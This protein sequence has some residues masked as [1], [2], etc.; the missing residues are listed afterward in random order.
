M[1]IHSFWESFNFAL[2][3]ISHTLKTQRNMRIH[4]I[5]AFLVLILSLLLDITK[6]ELII[7]FFSISFVIAAELINTSIE[8][9][10]NMLSQQYSFQARIAKNIAAGAVFM[11]AV[12]F[13]VIGYL[14]F[15][16]KLRRLTLDLILEI[17]Q[18]PFHL[19]F[20]NLSLLFIIV[21]YLKALNERGTPLKGGMPS[22]HSAIAF[23]I[24]TIITYLSGDILIASLAI[25]LALSVIQSRLESG[26]HDLPEVITGALVGILLTM[27][28][29]QLL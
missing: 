6:N 20:I 15:F 25:I 19:T 28:I 13:L 4:F 23:S 8:I 29:F 16:N 21:I 17:K 12:N 3:G 22:G 27:V 18:Q 24:V 5:L 26:T 1:Q 14:I 7:L 2:K 10:I 11:A 9:V